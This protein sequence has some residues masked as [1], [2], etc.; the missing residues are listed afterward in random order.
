MGTLIIFV[1][2]AAFVI[3]LFTIAGLVP[4]GRVH[5]QAGELAGALRDPE[6][7]RIPPSRVSSKRNRVPTGQGSGD[8]TNI[9]PIE[10][11]VAHCL[12]SSPMSASSIRTSASS[13]TRGDCLLSSGR[14]MATSDMDRSETPA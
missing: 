11:L 5:D 6:M 14:G 7:T 4:K 1:L 2:Y 10:M 8:S 13:G 12:A 3:V 9:P